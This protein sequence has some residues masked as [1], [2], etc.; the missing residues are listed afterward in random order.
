MI[1][2]LTFQLSLS[3]IVV[4]WPTE[5]PSV[6]DSLPP[7]TRSSRIERTSELREGRCDPWRVSSRSESELGA[8]WHPPGSSN[9]KNLWFTAFTRVTE[10]QGGTA[11]SGPR[12]RVGRRGAGEPRDLPE[13]RRAIR[14]P[15]FFVVLPARLKTMHPTMQSWSTVTAEREPLNMATYLTTAEAAELCRTSAETVR[16]WRHGQ[17]AAQFQGRP[18]FLYDTQ[19]VEQWL[20]NFGRPTCDQP[21]RRRNGR[22]MAP[23]R[24]REVVTRM[25]NTRSTTVTPTDDRAAEWLA[26]FQAG[27]RRVHGI[28]PLG[29]RPVPWDATC[30]RSPALVTT[31]RC[32]WRTG[33]LSSGRR[34]DEP[35]KRFPTSSTS[36]ATR[37]ERRYWA[38][39]SMAGKI[40]PTAKTLAMSSLSWS[41]PTSPTSVN[42]PCSRPHKLFGLGVTIDPVTVLGQMRAG[43]TEVLMPAG[44][45]AGVYLA[46]LME[47]AGAGAPRYYLRVILEHCYGD[48]CR[49][50]HHATPDRAAI[51]RSVR[52]RPW[53]RS[54]TSD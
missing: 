20:A 40:R 11:S 31:T 38:W 34:N 39:R 26:V 13:S 2:A 54:S 48:R 47:R 35:E 21:A 4:T 30:R 29:A 53:P 28:S 36:V 41:S 15:T 33:Y 43:G 6:V 22:S 9:G 51:P 16:Y 42:G 32:R 23:V 19:D 50:R 27:D 10:T 8:A 45:D 44:R 37:R 18:A 14:C 5:H 3:T 46:D 1:S 52:S 17:W 12:P 7:A 25:T 24:L 49:S